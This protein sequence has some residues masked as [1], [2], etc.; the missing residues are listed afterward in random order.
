AGSGVLLVK[1]TL[2]PFN[3]KID[4]VSAVK[5]EMPVFLIAV[6]VSGIYFMII[7]KKIMKKYKKKAGVKS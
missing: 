5:A 7:D 2:E 3:Y 4:P 6:I 1:S